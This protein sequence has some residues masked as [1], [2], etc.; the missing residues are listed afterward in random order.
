MRIS[1]VTPHFNGSRFLLEARQSLLDQTHSDWEWIIVDDGSDQEELDAL[2]TLCKKDDRIKWHP[3][4]G[5]PK[6]A[7]RCRNQGW[8]NA[9]GEHILFLDS[10][11]M[12]FPHALE[13]RTNCVEQRPKNNRELPYF[14][15]VAFREGE[16]ARWLWDDPEHAVPWLASLWSQTP[17]CQ[18]SGP[19]WTKEALQCAGGWAEDIQVWQDIDI[20]QRA[21]FKGVRF[22]PAGNATPD[23][24]Y[25]LHDQSLSHGNFHSS[26]KLRSRA[27]ILIQALEYARE[28]RVNSSES[29]ALASMIWSVFRNACLHKD[30]VLADKIIQRASINFNE[31]TNFLKQWKR[32]SKLRTNNISFIRNQMDKKAA[33]LF[34]KNTRK[35]LSTPV[36]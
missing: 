16:N 7:N 6:G 9:T 13:Q 29:Q 3:R 20:H 26:V 8:E 27:S 30:W 36:K 11:D 14:Q 35:I 19:L 1:V 32:K 24:L 31:E 28:G 21:H 17:P 12:L 10:D 33:L 22:T 2:D 23:I 4:E 5:G 18:T 25:R 15:T 34:P